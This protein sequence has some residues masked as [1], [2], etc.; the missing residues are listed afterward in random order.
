MERDGLV[1]YTCS[2]R[3]GFSGPLCL[4]PRDHAC[5]AS[6][7]LNGG[8][9]DLLT[10]AEY[11]CICPPGWSGE[12]PGEGRDGVTGAGPPSA[13][14]WRLLDWARPWGSA[15]QKLPRVPTRGSPCRFPALEVSVSGSRAPPSAASV[16][17]G[18]TPPPHRSRGVPA[19]SGGVHSGSAPEGPRPSVP[20]AVFTQ[21]VSGRGPREVR[22]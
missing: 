8:T 1:D 9:C 2:C 3:L 7:C 18:E 4:T 13:W 21:P 10:L 5:L 22:S 19:G 11:K 17:K 6:P 20:A 16:R 12:D 14:P 15:I